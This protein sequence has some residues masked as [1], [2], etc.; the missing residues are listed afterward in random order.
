MALPTDPPSMTTGLWP[1]LA[2]AGHCVR[3][4]S[5][6]IVCPSTVFIIIIQTRARRIVTSFRC[7]ARIRVKS[8]IYYFPAA[9]PH[10]RC[11][12][13][14]NLTSVTAKYRFYSLLFD[15]VERI[16]YMLCGLAKVFKAKKK[17]LGGVFL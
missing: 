6:D 10:A 4:E 15:F 12:Y 2:A 8:P 3:V 7:L 5:R 13:A 16:Y 14:Y 9:E 1:K 11:R 17:G